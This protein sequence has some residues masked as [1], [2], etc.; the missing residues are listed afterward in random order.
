MGLELLR[1]R[2]AEFALPSAAL[3]MQSRQKSRQGCRQRCPTLV[4]FLGAFP[5][6]GCRKRGAGAGPRCCPR[7]AR[8]HP[9]EVRCRGVACVGVVS[10]SPSPCCVF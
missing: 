2:Q 1:S 6:A 9:P 5:G 10:L 3:G 4:H 7:S 8:L